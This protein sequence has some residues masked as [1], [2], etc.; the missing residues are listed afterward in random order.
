MWLG[1]GGSELPLGTSLDPARR[2]ASCFIRE[3]AVEVAEGTAVA[4]R[5][6]GQRGRCVGLVEQLAAAAS[7]GN[8]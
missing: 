5:E 4:V 8:A 1:W 3:R 7:P 2:R 6:E